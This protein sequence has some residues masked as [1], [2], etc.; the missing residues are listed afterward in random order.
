[1]RS[2][3]KFC[4]NI[5]EQDT[6]RINIYHVV[7]HES[8]KTIEE[9]SIDAFHI[10]QPTGLPL[11]VHVTL[12][13]GFPNGTVQFPRTVSPTAYRIF[14]VRSCGWPFGR[15][16]I[17]GVLAT[18]EYDLCGAGLRFLSQV[19]DTFDYCYVWFF[20]CF[21][22]IIKTVLTLRKHHDSTIGIIVRS[23]KEHATQKSRMTLLVPFNDLDNRL[24]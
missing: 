2:A 10:H 12:A 6:G 24:E 9:R 16:E 13:G 3:E 18:I 20:L 1:M 7:C 4:G 8:A 19:T 23:V 22:P 11:T 5:R 17:R 14:S 15:S 21:L